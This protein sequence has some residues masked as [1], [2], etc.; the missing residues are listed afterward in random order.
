MKEKMMAVDFGY[1]FSTP[2]RLTVALPDSSNKTL[3]D[4][5]PGFLRMAWTYGNLLDKPLAAFVAPKTDWEVV[6]TPERDGKPFARSSWT[7]V[8][9]W[10]PVLENVYEDGA[11]TIRLEAAGGKTAAIVRVRLENRGQKAHRV[12]LRCE[13]PGAWAGVNPAW[14]QPEWDADVLIAGWM[15]RADR[16][17]LVA[18]GGD[19]YPV[20]GATALC[21]SWDLRPGEKREAWLVR[22]YHAYQP[23]LPE[24]RKKNWK[25]E[26][27]AAK[28]V[29]RKLL[30]R[31]A[32][33]TIPDSAV[34]N[35]FRACLAD[36]F[37]MRET[38]A[39]GTVT[40]S[41]GTELYRA[42]NPFEPL[43]VSILFDQLGLHKEAAGNA[44]MFLRQQGLDGNWADPEGWAHYMWGSAGIKSWAIME[45][46]LLTGDRAFLAA[47]YPRMAASSRWLESQRKRTRK[48]LKGKRPLSY[49]LM[50]RGMGDG[51]LKNDDDLYGVFLT[52]NILAVYADDLTVET[53]KILGKKKELPALRRIHAEALKDLLRALEDGAIV[54]KDF[55]WIPGVPGKISGSRWGALYSVFP[56]RLLPPEHELIT[57]TIRKFEEH[58]SS[59]GIPINTGWMKDGMWVAITL[60]NLAEVLLMRGDG[61]RAARY[62][63]ATLNHGTPLFS[64][65]EERGQEQGAK[66]CSGDRQHLWT[67][68]AVCRFLRDALAMEDGAV[69]HLAR[70][71]ARQWLASGKPICAKGL[72]THFGQLDFEICYDKKTRLVTGSV[73]LAGGKQNRVVLHLR[74]PGELKIKSLSCRKDAIVSEACTAVEFLNLNG[75]VNFTA[76]MGK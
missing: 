52:H 2:H 28:D 47:A 62:L 69:L 27:K 24:L 46:F 67:P 66:E 74:L 71:T 40:A 48:L 41:P 70:G 15:E 44:E 60:D 5:N 65:C 7:R 75:S 3:L 33:I 58:L 59:G 42:P 21:P 30:K 31:S 32:K 8:E 38:V 29:W 13:K 4:L 61:D 55:R 49:G 12:M 6:I 1:A 37:L 43:L 19:E 20:P 76:A 34:E 73:K 23:M 51:G 11:V 35:A 50:P 53:A 36:C 64:W 14:V 57:G 10:L 17:L 56:C 54:E 68:V 25:A 22:P 16:V 39:D 72:A 63:Y 45:H 18:L 26:F 9:G